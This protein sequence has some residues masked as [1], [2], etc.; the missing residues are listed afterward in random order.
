M[1][2]LINE[3]GNGKRVVYISYNNEYT[4]SIT[5]LAYET[6]ESL[7]SMLY[8]ANKKQDG[9]MVSFDMIKC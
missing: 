5:D 9:F 3:L 8:Y 2:D 1:H 4:P 6:I 7:K